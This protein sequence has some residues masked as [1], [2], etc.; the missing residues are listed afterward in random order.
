MTF[1]RTSGNV[2]I[3][4]A[5][6]DQLLDCK[7]SANNWTID[8]NN[9][10][11]GGNCHVLLGD[12]VAGVH[13][14]CSDDSTSGYGFGAYSNTR[15]EYDF[16]VRNDGKIYVGGSEVHDASDE[17]MKKNISTI[18]GALDIVKSMRGVTFKWKVEHDPFQETRMVGSEIKDNDGISHETYVAD[19]RY[20]QTNYGFIAQEMETVVPELITTGVGG[21]KYKRIADSNQISSILV[22]AIKE[23]TAKVEA[24][25]NA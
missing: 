19:I 17:R 20:Q 24:L 25:E 21:E 1:D 14:N 13:V 6:P 7:T 18:S 16:Y 2:G 9:I 5:S 3:G 8:A 12:R 22:E 11:G 23:L 10:G 15:S 4:T